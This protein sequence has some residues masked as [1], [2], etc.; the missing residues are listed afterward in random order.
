MAKGHKTGGRRKGS[1]NKNTAT[2]RER[3]MNFG[4]DPFAVLADIAKGELDCGVCLGKGKTRYQAAGDAERSFERICQSC[5]GSKRE[6]I[7]PAERG[8]AAAELAQYLEAKRKAIEHSGPE[9][10]PVQARVTVEF[11]GARPESI[12]ASKVHPDGPDN[13]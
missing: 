13:A 9:G 2:L 12:P 3:I 5:Y 1:G 10:G 4:C 6:R 11:V 8:K 7:S